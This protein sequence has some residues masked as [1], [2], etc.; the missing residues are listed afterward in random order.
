MA[1]SEVSFHHKINNDRE[2]DNKFP[3]HGNVTKDQEREILT[4]KK[5]NVYPLPNCIKFDIRDALNRSQYFGD[6]PSIEVNSLLVYEYKG[7]R[8]RREAL[9]ILAQL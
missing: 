4:C 9:Y 7:V 1:S 6:G 3:L 2:C 8:K 5:G